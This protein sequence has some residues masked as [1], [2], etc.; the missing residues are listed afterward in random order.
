MFIDIYV[1]V[2]SLTE[3]HANRGATSLLQKAQEFAAPKG[4][5]SNTPSQPAKKSGG[6]SGFFKKIKDA[7][8]F[9]DDDPSGINSLLCV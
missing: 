3:N 4:D 1:Q 9:S 5:G 7:T 6:I 2:H 8:G